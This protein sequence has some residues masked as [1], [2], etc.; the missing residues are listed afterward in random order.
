MVVVVVMAAALTVP[1]SIDAATDKTPDANLW[2][3]GAGLLFA[4]TTI[5]LWVA[6]GLTRAGWQWTHRH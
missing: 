2:P 1:F 4:G 5:G 6:A 3:A